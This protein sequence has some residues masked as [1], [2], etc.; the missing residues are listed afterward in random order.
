MVV[1][2]EI[3]KAGDTMSNKGQNYSLTD[4]LLPFL[5]RSSAAAWK[6][7]YYQVG[8]DMS[9]ISWILTSNSLVGLSA[10]FLSRL[11]VIH[12][13]APGK[14][15]LIAFA[16][17]EGRRRGLSDTSI[18]AIIEVIDL[19]AEPH[20]LNLRHITRM[21]TRAETLAAGSLLH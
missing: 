3:E 2:D 14:I 10:P 1:I 8:F 7:P 15:D 13:T 21:I 6:C 18:D 4:G 20:E 11:E 16:E 19:V 12:L 17:R 9:W 5:E